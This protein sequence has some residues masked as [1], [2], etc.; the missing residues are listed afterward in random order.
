MASL[1]ETAD[2]SLYGTT[3][4]GGGDDAG[5]VFRLLPDRTI[6][7]RDLQGTTT[8]KYPYA[9]L[10]QTSDGTFYGTTAGGGANASGTFF[11]MSASGVFTTYDL[12]PGFTCLGTQPTAGP[13]GPLT[14]AADGN[15]Y[16]P[17][18]GQV[19]AGPCFLLNGA[20]IRL[21]RGGELTKLSVP[22][23]INTLRGALVSSADGALSRSGD[24]VR[25]GRGQGL[26]VR[27]R[28]AVRGG[29][30][31]HP[32]RGARREYIPRGARP[33]LLRNRRRRRCREHGHN[34]PNV[35]LR[36]RHRPSPLSRRHRRRAA[37]SGPRSGQRQCALWRHVKGRRVRCGNDFPDHARRRVPGPL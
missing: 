17:V 1:L 14:L 22:I 6:V 23:E 27:A 34:L 30:H 28:R 10:I 18:A 9:A 24:R 25:D 8:G 2:G 5:V 11:A 13:V 31:F 15:L 26:L 20:V 4:N 12:P 16:A 37:E 19:F 3:V 35:S 32:R 7:T 21:T 29:A 36:R 33:E